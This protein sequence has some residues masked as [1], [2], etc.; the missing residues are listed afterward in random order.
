[1]QERILNQKIARLKHELRILQGTL[2]QLTCKM[3]EYENECN[4]ALS[5]YRHIIAPKDLPVYNETLEQFIEPTP[6]PDKDFFLTLIHK[7][8]R[9]IEITKESISDIKRSIII[10]NDMIEAEKYLVAKFKASQDYIKPVSGDQLTLS[11]T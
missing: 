5:Y 3:Q 6:S 11:I 1:M 9:A 7:H 8:S 10:Q 4:K 2:N